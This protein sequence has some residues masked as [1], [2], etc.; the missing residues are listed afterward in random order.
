MGDFLKRLLVSILK[1]INWFMRVLVGWTHFAQFA[2][3]WGT[4]PDP[5]GSIIFSTSTGSGAQRTTACVVERGVFSRLVLKEN[6]RML[7]ICCGDGFNARH[8]YASRA[9]SIIALDFDEDAIPHAR[10]YNSA[11]NITFIKQDIR[12]GLP[13][14]PFDN[15][16]WDAAIEHFTEEGDRYDHGRDRRA[17]WRRRR[18]E[19]L[20]A[21]RRQDR[22][23]EQCASRV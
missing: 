6:S 10:R 15:I 14:G 21:H 12:A 4:N 9:R 7:E 1:G 22:Q 5:N 2:L 16:V 8:F 13:E 20:H 18:P 17:P 3:Q 11:P 23:E 19:R